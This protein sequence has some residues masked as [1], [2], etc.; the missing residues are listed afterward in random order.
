LVSAQNVPTIS[1]AYMSP[2][3]KSGQ[4]IHGEGS[5]TR[6]AKTANGTASAPHTIITR[7]RRSKRRT[8]WV[9]IP[10]MRMAAIMSTT[11]A[12]CSTSAACRTQPPSSSGSSA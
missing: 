1:V 2:A 7:R 11:L 5:P 9:K 10:T 8:S 12:I 3:M 6:K 4:A